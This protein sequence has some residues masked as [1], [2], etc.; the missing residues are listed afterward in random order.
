MVFYSTQ[1]YRYLACRFPVDLPAEKMLGMF[2]DTYKTKC[3]CHLYVPKCHYQPSWHLSTLEQIASWMY[4]SPLSSS[5]NNFL[6]V[7]F[8][9]DHFDNLPHDKWLGFLA[10]QRGTNLSKQS[11]SSWL[12]ASDADSSPKPMYYGRPNL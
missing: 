8:N 4:F 5:C 12:A 10:M 1:T 3:T 11:R 6:V 7:T 2:R 9:I